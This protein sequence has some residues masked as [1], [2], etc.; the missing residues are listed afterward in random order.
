MTLSVIAGTFTF[1]LTQPGF[2]VKPLARLVK[3]T[4]IATICHMADHAAKLHKHF[5]TMQPVQ[6]AVARLLNADKGTCKQR[7]RQNKGCPLCKA[8]V[9]GCQWV[10]RIKTERH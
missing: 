7:N 6:A 1:E 3:G 10:R 2:I 8:V 5:E 9:R 4:A